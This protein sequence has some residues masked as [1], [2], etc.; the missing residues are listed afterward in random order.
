MEPVTLAKFSSPHP[1]AVHVMKKF[2]GKRLVPLDAD[3]GQACDLHFDPHAAIEVEEAILKLSSILAKD[4]FPIAGAAEHA[5]VV[6]LSSDGSVYGLSTNSCDVYFWKDLRE[7]ISGLLKG[8][9][10]TPVLPKRN[11]A[12]EH[13]FE[14]YLPEAKGVIWIDCPEWIIEKDP[15]VLSRRGEIWRRCFGVSDD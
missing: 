2:S 1:L 6:L 8:D 3:S 11:Y 9:P 13:G 7:A 5:G 4:L 14:E 15:E 12:Q 10:M